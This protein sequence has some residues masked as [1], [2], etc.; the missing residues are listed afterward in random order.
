MWLAECWRYVTACLER[1]ASATSFAEV[2]MGAISQLR[3]SLFNFGL[4]IPDLAF[5]LPDLSLPRQFGGHDLLLQSVNER[6]LVVLNRC[7]N[8]VLHLSVQSS[9]QARCD[10]GHRARGTS[11]SQVLLQRRG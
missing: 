9:V 7:F 3:S 2:C 4:K 11:D 6:G 8:H 5:E 10:G 1:N